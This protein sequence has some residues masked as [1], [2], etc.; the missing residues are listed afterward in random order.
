MIF[1]SRSSKKLNPEQQRIVRAHYRM[2][3]IVKPWT[4]PTDPRNF[5]RLLRPSP[6][7]ATQPLSSRGARR[8]RGDSLDDLVRAR[9]ERGRQIEA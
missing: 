7:A 8:A 6:L 3:G 5:H 4:Q 9:K 1:S 2:D